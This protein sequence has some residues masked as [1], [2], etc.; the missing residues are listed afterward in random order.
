MIHRDTIVAIAC[1]LAAVLCVLLT[2]C[3]SS[4]SDSRAPG[5]YGDPELVEMARTSTW[6]KRCGPVP[7]PVTM[8][9]DKNRGGGCVR[10]DGGEYVIE[11]DAR[12]SDA[13]DDVQHEVG[14]LYD[15]FARAGNQEL[16]AEIEADHRENTAWAEQNPGAINWNAYRGAVSAAIQG[17]GR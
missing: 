2:G 15:K 7:V 10:P 14:E 3:E 8:V 6:E 11:I 5:Y 17:A 4:A 13:R 9:W 12:T 1:L 16:T